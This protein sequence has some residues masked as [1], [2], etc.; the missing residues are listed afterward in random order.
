MKNQPKKKY[1]TPTFSEF[2]IELENGIAAG[3][4]N[5]QA[6][7]PTPTINEDEGIGGSKWDVDGF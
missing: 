5:V 4:G 1:V 6:G 2:Y 3:S 7:T